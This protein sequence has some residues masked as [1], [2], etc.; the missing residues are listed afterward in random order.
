MRRGLVLAS[1]ARVGRAWRPGEAWCESLVVHV[2]RLTFVARPGVLRSR[3]LLGIATSMGHRW[4]RAGRGAVRRTTD[5]DRRHGLRALI[6][7]LV[8]GMVASLLPLLPS[9]AVPAVATPGSPS[10]TGDLPVICGDDRVEDLSTE[11]R[12]AAVWVPAGAS[13]YFDSAVEIM[14]S[15]YFGA[16]RGEYFL[17]ASIWA[18]GIELTSKLGLADVGIIWGP[19]PYSWSPPHSLNEIPHFTNSTGQSRMFAV[20]IR[21]SRTFAGA[22]IRWSLGFDVPGGTTGVCNRA[23]SGSEFFGPNPAAGQQCPPCSGSTSNSV[24]T[25]SGNEHWTS[26]RDDRRSWAGAGLPAGLQLARRGLQRAPRP[27]LAQH[28]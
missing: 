18:D 27:G 12:Y 15:L 4:S 17:N 26:G 20:A 24:D 9:F 8:A 7:V 2:P 25:R 6:A 16:G 23:V 10:A 3:A 21:A 5:L 19:G 13:L 1:P 22:G 11:T 28:L 14:P